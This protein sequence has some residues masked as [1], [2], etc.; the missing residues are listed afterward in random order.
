MTTACEYGFRA[1]AALDPLNCKRLAICERAVR[2]R[3]IATHGHD[4]FPHR[5]FCLQGDAFC[6]LDLGGEP[7]EKYRSCVRVI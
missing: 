6:A 4:H 3:R 5:S 1:Q 7:F 2:F